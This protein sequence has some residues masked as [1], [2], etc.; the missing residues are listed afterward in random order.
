VLLAQA[1]DQQR[2]IMDNKGLR[3]DRAFHLYAVIRRATQDS[4][5]K[6]LI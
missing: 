1:H 4:V 2:K 3:I 5:S 6:N